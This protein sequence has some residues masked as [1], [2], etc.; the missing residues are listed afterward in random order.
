MHSRFE[1]AYEWLAERGLT[2]EDIQPLLVQE[3]GWLNAH[4]RD[5]VHGF[6]HAF[7]DLLEGEP[8]QKV[9][10]EADG[11]ARRTNSTKYPPDSVRGSVS[12][13]RD[14][15]DLSSSDKIYDGLA[16]GYGDETNP[17]PFHPDQPL[18]AMRF[19]LPESAVVHTPDGNL[20]TL[21]GH[22]PAFHPEGY[23][24]P[25]TGTGF[26]ASDNFTVPEYFAETSEMNPGAEMY[27]IGPDGSEHLVA[28][29]SPNRQWIEVVG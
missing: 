1:A 19:T 22:G 26:T 9:T 16:L 29:L 21:A 10:D 25:F 13:A 4:D 20:S 5:L 23:V 27:R 2:R 6:R 12:V 3:A 7:P 8:L 14:T 18:Y 11:D 17:S 28:V 15:V 24:Y